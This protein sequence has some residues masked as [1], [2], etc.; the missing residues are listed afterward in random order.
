MK[1]LTIDLETYSPLNIKE[2]GLYRYA[3]NCEILLLA[4][5]LDEKPV[6][7]I[8]LAEGEKVPAEITEAIFDKDILKTAYNAPF[9]IQVLKNYFE[10]EIDD[11]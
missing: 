2:V 10:K 3:E 6:E 11:S 9:E 7:I 1:T 5:A 4:Y 8:D